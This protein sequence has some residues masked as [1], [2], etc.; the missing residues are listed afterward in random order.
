V[1]VVVWYVV[2]HGFRRLVQGSRQ[3]RAAVTIV[4]ALV[5]GGVLS[6][7]Y[8]PALAQQLSP[9][10]VFE[11]YA[12][13][14]GPDEPLA[15]VGVRS[16]TAAYY[17]GGEVESF[18]DAGRAFTWLTE[19]MD[20]RRWLV[21]KSDDLP[22]LNSL[23]RKQVGR[24]LPVLDGRSSQILLVSNQL[25]E[26]RNESWL[27]SIL[28][29][30]PVEPAHRVDA[31]FE[32]QLQVLGW[33]ITDRSGRPV[34]D[35]VPQTKYR[36]RFFYKV[37]RPIT[38]SWKAFIHIDGFQRRFN[39]DH[40]VLDGKYPMSLWQPDDVIV[41]DA[42]IQLEPNFTPGDYTVFFGFFA[43]ES[44]FRVTRGPNHEN[45]V[46]GGALRVR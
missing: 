22:K 18:S 15:L 5:A 9:K 38:G 21:V 33:E 8:Y 40:A 31:L 37:L 39:G 10:E 19:R 7:W 43:G 2:Q 41:D 34:A 23:Y 16:R 17:S 45:R 27:T 44:R 36:M 3:P 13:L 32:D 6:F 30:D 14:H 42:E 4:A 20:Q 25:G 24:N 35:V 28:L 29:D 46:N 1:G 26:H 12:R 11:A